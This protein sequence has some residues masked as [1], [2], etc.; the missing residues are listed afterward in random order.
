MRA[1]KIIEMHKL[2]NQVKMAAKKIREDVK[3]FQLQFKDVIDKGL[4][5]FWDKDNRLLQKNDYDKLLSKE[6]M[7]HDNFQD[8]EK[9]LKEKLIMSKLED[10]FDILDQI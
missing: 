10:D 5:Y 7:N 9:G 6:R 8:M 1:K 2:M 3:Q 4:P